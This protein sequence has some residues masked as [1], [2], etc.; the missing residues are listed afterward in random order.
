MELAVVFLSFTVTLAGL[1]VYRKLNLRNN[2]CTG[3]DINKKNKPT[4]A[5]GSGIVLL[6]GLW[7]SV[8]YSFMAGNAPQTILLLSACPTIFALIGFFD[9]TKNK[10]TKKPLGWTI[11]AVPIAVF[12]LGFG[13]L[14]T[15]NALFAVAAGLFIAGL[16]SFQNTFA[17]LNGWE[18]GSGFIISIFTAT[19]VYNTPLFLPA[20][21]LSAAI[22]A[23]LLLNFYP[24]KVFPGD[25]GTL[26]IGSAIASI[27]I[28]SND[29]RV[30]ATVALFF[31]P[32]AFDFFF[33]K[34]RT[35][36]KDM[37]QQKQP[38]YKLLE[39]GLLSVPDSQKPRLDFAKFLMTLFGPMHEKKIVLIAWAVVFANC[40]LWASVIR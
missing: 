4:L 40:L 1:L 3:I 15:G 19:L 27:A 35:N 33:L 16:A 18:V 36:P 5:E 39:N 22:L 2:F 13:Y 32:H 28:L 26:L 10:F 24:A 23:L 37:T 11:R 21:G 34:L 6:L 29:L 9:D 17:G 12:S 14:F 30:Q 7:I 31:L 20:A 8:I 38:P 25:A